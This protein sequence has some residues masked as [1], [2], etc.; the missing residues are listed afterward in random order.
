MRP[1]I[2]LLKS[3]S[4]FALSITT[5]TL[6]ATAQSSGE[7]QQDEISRQ[8]DEVLQNA[9]AQGILEPRISDNQMDSVMADTVG[10][11]RVIT[12]NCVPD[13]LFDFAEKTD[14]SVN[15]TPTE[16][17]LTEKRSL[18]AK[19]L[20]PEA[21]SHQDQAGSIEYRVLSD[22]GLLLN[23]DGLSDPLFSEHMATCGAKANFWAD[24]STITEVPTA[25]LGFFRD[26]IEVFQ[27]L[28]FAMKLD[29]GVQL[30]PALVIND[31]SGLAQ[32]LA[33]QISSGD[34]ET[35][36]KL[37]YLRAYLNVAINTDAN[38]QS[39]RQYLQ[40][41]SF[42]ENI[43]ILLA[44]RTQNLSQTEGDELF[45]AV[46]DN[47]DEFCTDEERASQLEQ[48]L[49]TGDIK[50]SLDRLKRRSEMP[51]FQGEL[52]QRVLYDAIDH[53]LAAKSV[54]RDPSAKLEALSFILNDPNL[55]NA[56][57]ISDTTL[58]LAANAALEVGLLFLAEP[59]LDLSAQSNPSM[60][61]TQLRRVSYLLAA[62]K[63]STAANPDLRDTLEQAEMFYA[64]LCA[65][66]QG[67]GPISTP[68]Q[69]IEKLSSE[70]LIYLVERDAGSSRW[71]LS[72]DFYDAGLVLEDEN[73]R[74][75]AAD[76]K[77]LRYL[78]ASKGV[79]TPEPELEFVP[80]L[81]MNSPIR[82]TA[83]I[84]GGT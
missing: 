10:E 15:P 68:P 18:I 64:S 27:D 29:V 74:K 2:S 69:T 37:D 36:F 16:T 22:I 40:Y 52:T 49:Q 42:R 79:P 63:G 17:D 19:G 57:R 41:P 3:S 4:I 73:L 26:H 21:L 9:I 7:D 14:Q 33:S 35:S 32:I 60:E 66:D 25:D 83:D 67:L 53:S 75:R 20:Y 30:I 47:C 1:I 76:A 24:F 70:Q 71:A 8:L 61:T 56:G 62:C 65:I 55:A 46:L 51:S 81:L 5:L 84:F 34:E 77:R 38:E 48:L 54:G 82:D 11:A 72:L 44:S 23:G 43:L 78:M 12:P 59:I 6:T 45:E 80:S 58:G 28:P 50:P 13:T 39:L 31:E